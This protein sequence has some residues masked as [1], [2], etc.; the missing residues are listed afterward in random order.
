[1]RCRNPFRSNQPKCRRARVRRWKSIAT[2]QLHASSA[3][4]LPVV[5]SPEGV[6]DAILQ[7]SA[8]QLPVVS[9]L[10]RRR[11]YTAASQG[12]VDE[13]KS[14]SAS[15][16]SN[17]PN[18]QCTLALCRRLARSDFDIESPMES[19]CGESSS[20]TST[21]R[22]KTPASAEIESPITEQ[23]ITGDRPCDRCKTRQLKCIRS[24]STRRI[25][26]HCHLSHM[27]ALGRPTCLRHR[28]VP[29][30]QRR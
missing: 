13:S 15:A 14:Q 2:P 28:N 9:A 16:S 7:T 1:M 18:Q 30:T 20:S 29:T 25:C 11:C 5:L 19:L 6:G 4:Q 3:R 12:V 27:L 8:R 17:K 10:K 26:D 22:P 21:V 23:A 24:S